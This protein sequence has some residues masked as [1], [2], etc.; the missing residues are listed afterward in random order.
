MPLHVV[1]VI[2]Q[3]GEGS[4]CRLLGLYGMSLPF[5]KVTTGTETQHQ[6]L[7]VR[8]SRSSETVRLEDTAF[9]VYSSIEELIG[10]GRRS[11]RHPNC[12]VDEERRKI[13]VSGAR[14]INEASGYGRRDRLVV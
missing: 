1:G 13:F 5:K 10:A 4:K 3:G 11:R 2:I 14:N 12:A 7:N 6:A 8:S 9:H